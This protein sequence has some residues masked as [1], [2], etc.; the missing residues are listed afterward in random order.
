[1]QIVLLT[2]D[3]GWAIPYFKM[4]HAHNGI[5]KYDWLDIFE[6]RSKCAQAWFK[7]GNLRGFKV[8]TWSVVCIDYSYQPHILLPHHLSTLF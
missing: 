5:P 2:Q 3:P 1:M 4:S 8:I 7:F 6:K